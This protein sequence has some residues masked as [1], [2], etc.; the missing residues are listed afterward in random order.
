MLELTWEEWPG[1]GGHGQRHHPALQPLPW[2]R[3]W[4]TVSFT[5]AGNAASSS[6]GMICSKEAKAVPCI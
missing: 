2:N 5:H 1:F 3:T 6:E 4:Y